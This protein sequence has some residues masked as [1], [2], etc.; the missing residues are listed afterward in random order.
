MLRS[1][2]LLTSIAA[3]AA[4]SPGAGGVDDGGAARSGSALGCPPEVGGG[5]LV[6][7]RVNIDEAMPFTQ[8]QDDYP[9]RECAG[10]L[11]GL[12]PDMPDGY[13]LAPSVMTRPPIMGDDHLAMILGKPPEPRNTPDGTAIAPTEV[14]IFEVVRYTDEEMARFRD[15]FEAN[16]DA[17]ISLSIDGRDIMLAP[18][19]A[20]LIPGRTKKI[21]TGL[22]R[23][24]GD[25]LILQVSYTGMFD[26]QR[27][28]ALE[29]GDTDGA[30]LMLDILDRAEAEGLL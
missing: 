10:T 7:Q 15:W 23:L 17:Y 4:C 24:L 3:L 5:V 14:L 11:A 19:S 13:A 8:W 26:D 16:P 2:C 1:V 28:G 12:I 30:R 22:T 18:A 25:N 29:G 21:G 6:S 27:S 9:P 20:T